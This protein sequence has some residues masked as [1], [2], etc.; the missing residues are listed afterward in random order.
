MRVADVLYNDSD[1]SHGTTG[2][3]QEIESSVLAKLID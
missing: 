3:L 1:G 2:S